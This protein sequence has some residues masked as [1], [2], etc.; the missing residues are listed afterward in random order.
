MLAADLHRVFKSPN[1]FLLP[2]IN[3]I[4]Q[5]SVTVTVYGDHNINITTSGHSNSV[6]VSGYSNI[7]TVK[8]WRNRLFYI[9]LLP[10]EKKDQ[11]RH[12]IR[13]LSFLIQQYAYPILTTLY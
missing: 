12:L 6:T 5:W 13:D 10:A 8:V 4:L 7:I 9:T 11:G 2:M 1:S 3:C